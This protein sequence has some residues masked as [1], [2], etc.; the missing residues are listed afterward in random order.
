VGDRSP[1]E[2]EAEH[3]LIMDGMCGH[4]GEVPEWQW[5]MTREILN[6]IR[7]QM[8]SHYFFLRRIREMKGLA[9]FLIDH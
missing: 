5:Y 7:A 6:D 4:D 8:G 1:L 2:R 3:G 9:L